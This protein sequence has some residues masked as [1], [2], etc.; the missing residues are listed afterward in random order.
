MQAGVSLSLRFGP[1]VPVFVENFPMAR[2][3]DASWRQIMSYLNTNHSG[4]W[5]K[6]FE[7]L[8]PLAMDA[9]LLQIRTDT[10]MRCDFLQKKCLEP[11]T[12]AAQQVTGR[13]MA[14]KFVHQP[15]PAAPAEAAAQGA[16]APSVANAATLAAT[17]IGESFILSPD[18]SFDSFVSGGNN[19]LAYAAAQAVA[20]QPGKAYNPL[21]IHGGVGLGKTHLLQAVCQRVLERRPGAKILYISCDAFV[22][23][24]IAC[25]QEGRM[26]EFRNLYRHVDLLVVDDIHF[27]GGKERVQEEFFHTFNTLFQA[28]KQVILSSDAAPEEIPE[29]EERLMSRFKWGVVARVGK[30]D[31]ETRVAILR[32]KAQLRGVTLPPEVAELVAKRIASNARELEGML[33]TILGHVRLQKRELDLA[34]AREVLGESASAPRSNQV[35]MQTITEAV[36]AYYNIPLSDLQ[37]RRRHKSVTEPRQLCM[38]LARRHTRFSLEEIGGYFGGRDHTTVMHSLTTVDDR[39]AR[40]PEYASQVQQIEAQVKGGLD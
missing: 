13:L 4:L 36:T 16:G 21:F 3:D 7:E 9:G 39:S 22:N 40:D 12:E 8:E 17:H 38:W 14:V 20:D 18:Y 11:F 26:L 15:A 33:N 35:T 1:F 25:V 31:F 37:S 28:Q 34:L 19:Q 10:S 29:L 5:R 24:F 27:L 32:S 23:E 2:L 30:P 6:W